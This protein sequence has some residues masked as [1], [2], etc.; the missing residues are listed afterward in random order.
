MD[1]VNQ[2]LKAC[3]IG[4]LET[5]KAIV[6]GLMG[7]DDIVNATGNYEYGPRTHRAESMRK[8]STWMDFSKEWWWI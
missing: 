6:E 8:F 5:V 3:E 4:E 2:L 7:I 1:I